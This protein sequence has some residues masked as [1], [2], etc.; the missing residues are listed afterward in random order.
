MRHGK[1]TEEK[2]IAL[3]G[4]AAILRVQSENC[5]PT[6]RCDANLDLDEVV[7][8]SAS[9][10][11]THLDGAPCTLTAYYYPDQDDLDDNQDD[12]GGVDW[13]IAGYEIE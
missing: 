9:V 13:V 6:S 3:V 2:A 7:E 10:D 4:A 8:F 1:L 5:E 11:C 12:L